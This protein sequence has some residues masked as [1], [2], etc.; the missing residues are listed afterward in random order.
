LAPLNKKITVV[1][2]LPELD[3]GG[4]ERGTLEVGRYLSELGHRSIV[5]SSGGRMLEQLESEGSEHYCWD[6][7]A[8][9]LATLLWVRK[10]RK[11]LIEVQPDILHLRSRLPAW[12]GY[13]AWRKM[14]I[15]TRPKLVTTVHGAN[16]VSRYSAVML[17]GERVIA[18]SEMIKKYIL[19]NYPYLDESKVRVIC[20]GVDIN[21]YQPDYI[22]EPAWLAKWQQDF[23]ELRNKFVLCLPG[24]ISRR[25]GHEHFFEIMAKLKLLNL[26]IHGIIVGDADKGKQHYLQELKLLRDKL[27]LLSSVSFIAHRTDL[28]QIMAVSNVVLSLSLQ[29]EAFGRTS[30]EA[31]SLGIPVIGYNHGG[32]AEQLNNLLPEGNVEKHDILSVVSLIEKWYEQKPT[33]AVNTQYTLKNMLELTLLTYSEL[34]T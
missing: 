26:P 31:L 6:V 27:D 14:N 28:K 5:I 22:A 17:K 4:V 30:I 33:I 25:K 32:V 24:R 12:I 9:R 13:L 15:R 34:I 21:E 11:L 1:Q 10:L 29:P 18:I 23:P 19:T 7:G 2:M 20:R 3:G 8:K 16:S